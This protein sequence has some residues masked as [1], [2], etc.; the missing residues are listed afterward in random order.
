MVN[1]T[2][3]R[4]SRSHFEN[5]DTES[6]Q[7]GSVRIISYLFDHRYGDNTEMYTPEYPD[8]IEGGI[9][10]SLLSDYDAMWD[11]ADTLG[12]VKHRGADSTYISSIP[13]T[14]YSYR[15]SP[16]LDIKKCSICLSEFNYED[17]M[18]R[19]PS[20]MH[21]FHA[22]CLDKWLKVNATCPICRISLFDVVSD[23]S[24]KIAST[25]IIP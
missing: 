17:K 10:E 8:I 19:M 15:H 1:R 22:E 2:N 5:A 23:S 13:V 7:V 20:C 24:D 4:G 9:S 21:A 6:D 16:T 12:Y 3:D 11:L 14:S 25:I 18:K